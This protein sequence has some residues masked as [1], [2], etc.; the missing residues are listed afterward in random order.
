MERNIISELDEKR[1]D[2]LLLYTPGYSANNSESIERKFMQKTAKSRRSGK[3][4]LLVAAVAVIIVAFSG[5]ALATAT[6]FDF[7]RIFDSFFNNP[8][9]GEHRIYGGQAVNAGG[10]EMT[11]LSAF[12]DSNTAYMLIE[13]RD[14]EGS[15]LSDGIT[16]LSENVEGLGS[17]VIYYDGDEN[18]VTMVLTLFLAGPISEGD[19]LSFPISAI[20]TDPVYLGINENAIIG[21]WE[22]NF[23]VG[24]EMPT[25]S[26][27]VLPAD[28]P[29]FA[30]LEFECTPMTT[31]VLKSLH[32]SVQVGELVD[33][34]ESFGDPF[35]TLIDGRVIILEPT[36]SI[37][38]S[39]IGWSGYASEFFNIEHLRSITFCGEEFVIS[40]P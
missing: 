30:R 7:G 24:T 9:S 2:E 18:K 29:F 28:S 35:L 21:P 40:T 11:L 17:D 39:D 8:A 15:R 10:L 6:G 13:I 36:G 14:V 37:F 3:R 20:L 26:L 4:V 23:T 27:T 12:V 25:K 19:T 22:M 33:Y 31:T 16:A 5:V 1:I 32:G 38:D 34:I